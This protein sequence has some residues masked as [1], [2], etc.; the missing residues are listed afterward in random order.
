MFHYNIYRYDGVLLPTEVG[1]KTLAAA[2]ADCLLLKHLGATW[3]SWL[4]W[5]M[6]AMMSLVEIDSM[7]PLRYF[8][9]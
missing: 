8:L 7:L 1:I 4:T 3:V 2:A 6:D 5:L 9:S